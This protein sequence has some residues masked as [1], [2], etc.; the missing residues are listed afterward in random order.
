MHYLNRIVV[1][2]LMTCMM[3]DE[4]RERVIDIIIL[5][6]TDSVSLHWRGCRI[7]N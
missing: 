2:E 4:M 7:W 6:Q 1:D 3:H 5:A